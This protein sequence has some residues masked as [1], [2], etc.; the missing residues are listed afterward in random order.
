MTNQSLDACLRLVAD[1]QRRRVID[2]LRHDA[3]ETTTFDDLVDRLDGRTPDAKDGPPRD[4]LVVQLHH[5]HLP[6][7]SD[8]GVVEYDHRSGD[9]RYRPDER[10][11]AVIDSLPGELSHPSP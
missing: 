1:R 5:V 11:E 6:T 4:E 8:Y 2:H 3:P 10:V 7:L 9:V